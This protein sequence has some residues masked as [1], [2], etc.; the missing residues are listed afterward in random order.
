MAPRMDTR[1]VAIVCYPKHDHNGAFAKASWKPLEKV[2][3]VRYYEVGS[4]DELRDALDHG[5]RTGIVDVVWLGGHGQPD[6]MQLG[7][8]H[9]DE[10]DTFDLSDEGRFRMAFSR[11][12]AGA[13]IVL[14]S[15]S[16][17]AGGAASTNLA[18]MVKRLAPMS[19]VI[20][21]T[22]DTTSRTLA[23]L[24]EAGRLADPGYAWASLQGAAYVQPPTYP[25]PNTPAWWAAITLLNEQAARTVA[26]W[27]GQGG[28][29]R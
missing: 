24:T 12:A 10:R 6:A 15:C 5:T 19:R 7:N 23:R 28:A 17:G 18:N 1:L 26:S 16:T 11:L 25:E 13:T 22:V 27:H 8:S 29:T 20:A 14:D 2:Y 3:N 21:P 9:G 4:D